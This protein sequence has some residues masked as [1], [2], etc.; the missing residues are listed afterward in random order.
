MNGSGLVKR[1]TRLV[2]V[3]PDATTVLP[4]LIAEQ[5]TVL[6][7]LPRQRLTIQNILLECVRHVDRVLGETVVDDGVDDQ[8]L[9]LLRQLAR[10]PTCY[11]AFC[12]AAM[13]FL[14]AFSTGLAGYP[15][16]HIFTTLDAHL[17][18]DVMPAV[19]AKVK[20]P[21]RERFLGIF[22]AEVLV[23]TVLARALERSDERPFIVQ[24]IL[25]FVKQAGLMSERADAGIAKRLAHHLVPSI[26]NDGRTIFKTLERH[27]LFSSSSPPSPFDGSLC[28]FFQTAQLRVEWT[29]API[30][31]GGFQ[32]ATSIP[33]HHA[34]PNQF[35][36][37]V[38]ST[39]TTVKSPSS[40]SK[41]SGSGGKYAEYVATG[42]AAVRTL[43]GGRASQLL[44]QKDILPLCAVSAMARKR[45]LKNE[46]R[47]WVTHLAMDIG[48]FS[49]IE[50]LCHLFTGIQGRGLETKDRSHI[51][52][53]V[54]SYAEACGQHITA[55]S[56]C[57][58]MQTSAFYEASDRRFSFC[59]FAPKNGVSGEALRELLIS[60]GAPLSA[61][62]IERILAE[63]R[64]D[65]S[66]SVACLAHFN[67]LLAILEPS[68]ARRDSDRTLS[69]PP[70]FVF[71]QAIRK[72]R[73]NKARLQG[74][75][76]DPRPQEMMAIAP[77]LPF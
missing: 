27:A 10:I 24:C 41:S 51:Q 8:P 26:F 35:D 16:E 29:A 21:Q 50:D 9:R 32:H 54:T 30:R 60:Q 61:E 18:L 23:F 67:E 75:R 47:W 14:A 71:A 25:L 70:F 72:E 69:S 13:S 15:L 7:L 46:D 74:D 76:N 57:E 33:L 58:T 34:M 64:A 53:K 66:G 56:G 62:A 2:V 63:A 12:R 38:L 52:A 31:F 65:A 5:N 42:R 73:R 3:A 44:V 17:T 19:M 20:P 43:T 1:F 39:E 6:P 68:G 49:D 40:P 37:P 77:S 48:D 22:L 28:D 55:T 4:Q 45:H 59:P 36:G 11:N